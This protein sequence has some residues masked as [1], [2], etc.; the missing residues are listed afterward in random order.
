VTPSLAPNYGSQ[1][2]AHCVSFK[3]FDAQHNYTQH[4][5]TQHNNTKI[6]GL[7]CDTAQVTPNADLQYQCNADIMVLRIMTLI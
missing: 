6:C 5:D 4:N 3:H 2:M 7:N 1:L